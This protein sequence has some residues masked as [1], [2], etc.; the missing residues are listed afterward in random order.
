MAQ[1]TKPTASR[2]SRHRIKQLASFCAFLIGV[3]LFCVLFGA[4]LLGLLAL[5]LGT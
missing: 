1:A 5:L 2:Q 3:S 4:L